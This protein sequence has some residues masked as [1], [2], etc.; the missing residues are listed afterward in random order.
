MRSNKLIAG[1]LIVLLFFLGGCVSSMQPTAFP[2][3]NKHHAAKP[4][5]TPVQLF[6][7][8]QPTRPFEAVAKLNVHIEKTFFI[9]SAFDEVLPKLEELARQHGA[10]A[11][12]DVVE[13]KSRLNETFI[14]N[15][16]ATAVAFTD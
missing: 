7:D 13:K 11:L 8:S 5:G 10:D 1:G 6:K 4:P 12:I 9:P 14:Y 15:V 2:V 3:G 16:T